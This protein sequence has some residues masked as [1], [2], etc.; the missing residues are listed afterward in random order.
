MLIF[1][2]HWLCLLPDTLR[3]RVRRTI[4]FTP[5]ITFSY[6]L[7]VSFSPFLPCIRASSLLSIGT[8][9]MHWFAFVMCVRVCRC[10]CV[11]VCVDVCVCARTNSD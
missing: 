5:G 10:M 9:S 11:C 8:S 2:P 4:Y 6:F 3:L 7:A 1:E